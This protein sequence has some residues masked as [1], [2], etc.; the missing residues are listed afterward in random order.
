MIGNGPHL[1]VQVPKEALL[2]IIAVLWPDVSKVKKYGQPGAPQGLRLYASHPDSIR[3]WPG[4]F[5]YAKLGANYGPSLQAHGAAQA[6]GFDQILWLFGAERQVTEAGASNFFVVMHNAHTGRLE[7]VTA[8]LENQLILPGVTRRSVLELCRE[9]LAERT[10]GGLAPVQVVERMLT[11]GEIEMAAK[12]GRIVEAFV[13]GTAVCFS[14]SGLSFFSGLYH[15]LTRTTVLHHARRADS[16]R[17]R[18]YQ[19]PRCI[20]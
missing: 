12:E 6:L 3:A 4:G 7:M 13:S 19:H 11:I 16:Q 2:F 20:G 1:G 10:V 14:L 8:P 9:R 5:G 17:R 18:R 15:Q